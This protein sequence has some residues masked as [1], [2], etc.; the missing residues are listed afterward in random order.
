MNA[1]FSW[2]RS[3]GTALV[4][5]AAT[6]LAVAA[7]AGFPSAQTDSVMLSV[8]LPD[9]PGVGAKVFERKAC[10]RCHAV[11]TPGPTIGPDLGRVSFFGDVLDLA[12][13][14]WN[15][16]PVMQQRMAALKIARPVLSTN[17]AADLVAFLTAY[18]YYDTMIREAGNPALGR[19]VFVKK[20]C[21]GCHEAAPGQSAIAPNLEKYRGYPTA[22]VIA[23]AMW[24][25]SPAM[26]AAMEAKGTPWPT[27]AGREMTDLTA[28]LQA[29]LA[30]RSW[31][32][33][34]FDLGNPRLGWTLFVS[35]GCN[36][37]HSVAG[38]GGKGAPDLGDRGRAMARSVPEIAGLMWNHS[39]KM[40][41][42]FIKRG[43]VRAVFAGGEMADVISY[44][45]FV[46]YANV[47]GTSSRGAQVFGKSCSSCHAFGKTM[48]GPDLLSAPG[49]D[50]P[51]GIIAAMW[52][53][54]AA[55]QQQ[56]A[57]IY[58]TWPH[59]ERGDTADLAAF[60]ISR[61]AATP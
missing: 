10:S 13:S 24:R 48:V 30:P 19:V 25:H 47:R 40:N 8:D 23:E 31:E 2:R 16:A 12:G 32:P 41:R 14:F 20:G 27:F 50:T 49:L 5:C 15:H 54:S 43:M 55:M 22:I 45:Y 7:G 52:N 44:L 28:Y 4:I 33:A 1:V 6:V 11:G 34:V 18:R 57:R 17:E 51:L 26:T 56:A 61:R 42:E 29:G 53:H 36:A 35:K 46:N 37:C 39:Q 58:A 3:P 21:A 9:R 60:L 38:S 59:L